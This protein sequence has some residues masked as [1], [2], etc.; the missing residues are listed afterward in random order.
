MIL[1]P[2]S[3]LSADALTE[4][5]VSSSSAR[6][7]D[8]ALRATGERALSYTNHNLKRVI[9]K[10]L[11]ALLDDFPTLSP[12]SDTFTDDDGTASHLLQAHGFLP[13][14]SSIPHVLVTIWLHRCYP[15][16]APVVYVFPTNAHL[17][18]PDHPFFGP[19]GAVASPYLH[20]WR[21]PSSN[22][23]HLARNLVNIFGLCHPYHF[24]MTPPPAA[25]ASL[26]S[27]REAIDRLYARLHRDAKQFQPRIEVEIERFGSAQLALR[28]RAKTI[29][30]GLR[31]LEG[32]RLSL[33]KCLE[34]KAKDANVLSAWLQEHG[35]KPQSP[36]EMVALEAVDERERSMVESAAA[37]GAIDDAVCVLDEALAAGV[38]DFGP[39]IKQVRCL[40]REQFFHKAL[41][42]K[43]QQTSGDFLP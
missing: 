7:V 36:G 40:A 39:Y 14:S 38:L 25:D 8:A 2:V 35:G 21:Y 27:N 20:R 34:E 1:L 18:L 24:D 28:D 4:G 26:A 32:E 29:E 13:L 6:F 42:R 22:L 30:S 3:H 43:I 16:H 33:E 15:Y 10:H 37:A 5:M 9:R 17:L 19:S 41:V 31:D 11:L 23:S 12:R